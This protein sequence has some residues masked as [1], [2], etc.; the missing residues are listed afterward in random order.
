MEQTKILS[1]TYTL[2]NGIQIPKIGLGTWFIPD[3][4]AEE[5][6]C[7]AVKI[8]YRHIDTAQA[9]ENESGVGK[10][11]RA[12]G[13]D[14][15]DLFITTKLA[16]EIKSYEEAV[17]A[18]DG[19]LEKMGLDYIDLMLIHSPQPWAD[20]RGGDMQMEIVKHGAHW[21]TLIKQGNSV[22]SVF[23]ISRNMTLRIFFLHAR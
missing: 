21:K 4:E 19:S 13:I 16:A 12:C 10:G 5:A 3:D 17:Q 6:I 7:N 1:E 20:F 11:V 18:I 22:R 2:T 23:L 8:G 15:K 14:R 9:Y